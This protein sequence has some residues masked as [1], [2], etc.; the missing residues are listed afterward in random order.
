MAALKRRRR[1]VTRGTRQSRRRN[2]K[3]RQPSGEKPNRA[4]T[5]VHLLS[6][7]LTFPP[8]CSNHT[9]HLRYVF[10]SEP[11]STPI[12]GTFDDLQDYARRLL[13]SFPDPR[14]R[15]VRI[16]LPAEAVSPV[17]QSASPFCAG[18][19]VAGGGVWAEEGKR[20]ERE[21]EREM[22][23]AEEGLSGCREAVEILTRNPK[24]GAC[25]F[26]F[27]FWFSSFGR[28]SFS[29]SVCVCEESE[30]MIRGVRF[31]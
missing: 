27:W 25:L 10:F 29:G 30:L 6:Y 16:K 9:Y 21:M 1:A 11:A 19:F 14:A 20:L 3:S 2:R 18:F 17:P 23:R 15:G 28:F 7:S 24:K 12:T 8:K 31:W 4:S 26:W 22:E 5:Y 13:A